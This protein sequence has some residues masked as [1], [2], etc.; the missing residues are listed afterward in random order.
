MIFESN[1]FQVIFFWKRTLCGKALKKYA[2]IEIVD[3]VAMLWGKV[4]AFALALHSL[5]I[6]FIV[7]AQNQLIILSLLLSWYDPSNIDL[8][9][10]VCFWLHSNICMLNLFILHS[11]HFLILDICRFPH[12]PIRCL[13]HP[14]KSRVILN[15]WPYL[16]RDL[17]PK[18]SKFFGQQ[19]LGMGPPRCMRASD[20]LKGSQSSGGSKCRW[21]KRI[22][23][24]LHFFR[25]NIPLYNSSR[26]ASRIGCNHVESKQ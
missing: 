22:K 24:Y 21:I 18:I 11:S 1:T 9:L 26:L 4:I 20:G 5:I 25:I 17:N 14:K 2:H 8:I 7:F 3:W 12:H 23:K 10:R 16:P 13:T 19:D 15:R 6:N